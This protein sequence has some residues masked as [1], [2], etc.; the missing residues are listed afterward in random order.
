MTTVCH[1]IYSHVLNAVQTKQFSLITETQ[2]NHAL[3]LQNSI[4]SIP[5]P[6]HEITVRSLAQR[7]GTQFSTLLCNSV[8]DLTHIVKLERIAWS[9]AATGNFFL[10]SVFNF[11]FF[12][13]FNLETRIIV[14]NKLSAIRTNP[15][16]PVATSA[17][18]IIVI[19]INNVIIIISVAIIAIGVVLIISNVTIHINTIIVVFKSSSRRHE[20]M[21][22]ESRVSLALFLARAARNRTP[23]SRE[24]LARV[25]RRH[26]PSVPESSGA[27]HG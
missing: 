24:T 19:I 21:S 20:C 13:I 22:R 11:N 4:G 2:H 25:P 16:G 27:T 10:L 17:H 3:V 1:A 6:T 15:R 5:S 23:E 26:G 7:L 9:L 12:L 18:N 14:T 8:P